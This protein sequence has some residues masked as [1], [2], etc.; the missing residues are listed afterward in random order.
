MDVSENQITAFPNE[1]CL[2]VNLVTLKASSNKLESLDSLK[3][4]KRNLCPALCAENMGQ[5]FR[6]LQ[7]LED[8]IL[9][10][11]RLKAVHPFIGYLESLRNIDLSHN[12]LT[13][14]PK[15]IGW[16]DKSLRKLI[17]SFNQIKML[18]GEF[19]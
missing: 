4:K 15:Q 9:D 1:L 11:N 10:H 16:L 13:S 19:T 3:V 2:L 14:A 6:N 18:P 8:L 17:L 12:Q 7:K 5:D